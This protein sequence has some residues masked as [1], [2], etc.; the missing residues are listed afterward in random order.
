MIYITLFIE[1]FKVGILTVGGGL[2][3]LPFYMKW[4]INLVGLMEIF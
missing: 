1:F 4:L 3:S 2:A